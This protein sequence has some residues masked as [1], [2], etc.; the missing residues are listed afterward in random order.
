MFATAAFGKRRISREK[1]DG[2]LI[3]CAIESP[4][5]WRPLLHHIHAVVF[6]SERARS[7]VPPSCYEAVAT[8]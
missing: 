3:E 6:K 8:V 2:V 4:P 7:A 1:M 5:E